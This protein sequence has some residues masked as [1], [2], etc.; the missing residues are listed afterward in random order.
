[1]KPVERQGRPTQYP[2]WVV[3]IEGFTPQCAA[4]AGDALLSD[5]LL[6]ANGS[7]GMITHESFALCF[8]HLSKRAFG[9]ES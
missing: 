7:A 9:H 3:V 5:A 8:T 6:A 2:N 1:M 4:A